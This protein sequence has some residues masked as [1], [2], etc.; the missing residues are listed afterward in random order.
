MSGRTPRQVLV[1]GVGELHRS[2][3]S[4][5]RHQT[6]LGHSVVFFFVPYITTT[7]VLKIHL[8]RSLLF[9]AFALCYSLF[10]CARPRRLVAP[11]SCGQTVYYTQITA[12]TPRLMRV[13]M[14]PRRVFDES[15]AR[16]DHDSTRDS[17]LSR[18][19]DEYS[20]SR[21]PISSLAS[22]CPHRARAN[23]RSARFVRST[24][25]TTG[26]FARSEPALNSLARDARET[27]RRRRR[28]GTTMGVFYARRSVTHGL[29]RSRA[30]VS[31]G[32][33]V[34]TAAVIIA[35]SRRRP[36]DH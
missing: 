22:V 21:S 31:D 27:V 17:S 13:T 19:R 18:A 3:R 33:V 15:T 35:S 9:A 29:A 10:P 36:T 25:E 7:T 24:R 16:D 23:G 28:R 12:P 34:T 14:M 1:L 20:F 11:L 4:Q 30:R 32:R 6:R 5:F 2:P 8:T 26:P